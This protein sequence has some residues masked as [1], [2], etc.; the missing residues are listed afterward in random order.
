MS[1]L[2]EKIKSFSKYTVAF[3]I[4]VFV[5]L[6]VGLSTLGTVQPT[7]QAYELKKG[8][9]VVFKLEKGEEQTS[10]KGVYF[11]VGTVY[12]EIGQTA[13]I[14]MR[15]STVSATTWYSSYFGEAKLD[16]LY[17]STE[18]S[19][20]GVS[21]NWFTPYDL[22][23]TN[24]N[25][26]SYPYYELTA[27]TCNLLVNEVVFLADDGSV[28]KATVDKDKSNGIDVEKA[29]AILDSQYVP[30]LAQSS[31]FRFGEEEA[32]S[33]MTIAEMRNGN[34]FD[35]ANKY[36]IDGTYNALGF[37]LLAIGAIIFGMSP[38]GLRF[39]P[40]LAT[41]GTLLVA[42]AFVKNLTKS[43]K[44]AFWFSLLFALCGLTLT[45]GRVGTPFS[46]G[47]FFLMTSLYLA[48]RFY[49]QGMEEANFKSALPVLFSGIFG[50]L[51]ICVNGAFTVPVLG[52]VALFVVGM[53]RQQ[54]AKA[55]YMQKAETSE[56]PDEAK[57]AVSAEYRY[58]NTTAP[59][60][61]GMALILGAALVS[62]LAFLPVYSVFV[63]AY[64]VPSAPQLGLLE[65]MWKA[66][67]GG[68]VGENA[69]SVPQSGFKLAYNLF[70]GTGDINA[71]TFASVN[72]VALAAALAGIVYAVYRLITVLVRKQSGK[73]VRAEMRS[74]LLPLAAVALSLITASFASNAV[75]F[76]GTAYVFAF[77]LAAKGVKDLSECKVGKIILIVVAVL[78]AVYFVLLTPFIFSIPM[79]NWVF[80]T[81][82]G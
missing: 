6:L 18:E 9:T 39:L 67:A 52:S 41:V 4:L 35:N 63:K 75:F 82:F 34:A 49:A 50:A 56:L 28:I 31:F 8:S 53:I 16:N 46:F 25:I 20:K 74:I 70:V 73:E 13:S 65:L 2:K 72:Y 78:L 61:F 66:F 40:F 81:L 43:D 22:S 54:K 11:N 1:K 15:R 21:F 7:G 60:L 71:R 26:S 68:F 79:P 59:L 10:V 37:D 64:D 44:A 27:P 58:K 76:V 62:I 24:Y 42:R 17:S 33:M 32:Y 36:H 14:R 30:N 45:L 23:E 5:F 57:A 38:F 77:F 47:L 3:V 51:S 55:Y 48:H 69:L 80:V 29:S 19:A 12:N